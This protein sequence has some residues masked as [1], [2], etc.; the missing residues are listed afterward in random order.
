MGASDGSSRTTDLS[1]FPP[2]AFGGFAAAGTMRVRADTLYPRSAIGAIK[3]RMS[4]GSTIIDLGAG[5][6]V[7][8]GQLWRARLRVVALEPSM[9]NLDQLTLALPGVPAVQASVTALPLSGRS[10]DAV[11]ISGLPHRL[12]GSGLAEI[13]RVLRAGALLV[14]MQNSL[15]DG[16]DWVARFLHVVRSASSVPARDPHELH[17]RSDPSEPVAAAGGFSEA[18]YSTVAHTRPCGAEGLVRQ[19]MSC[20]SVASAPAHVRARVLEGLQDLVHGHPDLAGRGNFE[21]PYVTELWIWRA[22]GPH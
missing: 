12:D 20:H 16:V 7:L 10:A 22:I 14:F 17:D 11:V 4:P 8:S 18:E 3:D 15:D 5:T 2:T 13:S 21:C 19:A 6:G 9:P 1:P